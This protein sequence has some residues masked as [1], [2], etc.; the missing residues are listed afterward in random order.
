MQTPKKIKGKVNPDGIAERVDVLVRHGFDPGTLKNDP[1]R[2][3]GMDDVIDAAVN[4]VM[5]GRHAAG[6]TDRVSGPSRD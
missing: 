6:L 1:P 2:G 3:A 4:L 5:A